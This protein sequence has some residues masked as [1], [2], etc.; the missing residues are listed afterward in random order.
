MWDNYMQNLNQPIPNFDPA[1]SLW[2]TT[3]GPNPGSPN[4][5]NLFSPSS[6]AFAANPTNFS[7][8]ATNPGLAPASPGS[9][10]TIL[11]PSLFYRSP[12]SGPGQNLDTPS[13]NTGSG[14]GNS[15]SSTSPQQHQTTTKSHQ[16]EVNSGP[17]M[18]NP[19]PTVRRWQ[20][21]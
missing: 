5:N 19:E 4:N 18:G 9:L 10:N 1:N 11:N 13:S 16:V 14:S 2:G 15:N 21:G 17:F 8:A 6:N 7:S 3:S 12:S 20:M